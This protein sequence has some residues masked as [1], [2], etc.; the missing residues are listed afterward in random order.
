MFSVPG[1]SAS[2]DNNMINPDLTTWQ[3]VAD[4]AHGVD[5]M[6]VTPYG[7]GTSTF[8]SQ[9]YSLMIQPSSSIEASGVYIWF[10]SLLDGAKLIPG[11]SY[12]VSFYLPCGTD[13][14]KAIGEPE[15][16][17]NQYYNNNT[18]L[19]AS[20]TNLNAS[21]RVGISY[22]SN[23]DIDN[24]DVEL[25]TT[26][27]EISSDNVDSYFGQKLTASFVCPDYIGNAYLT[28]TFG[29][30]TKYTLPFSFYFSD[31]SLIDPND[32]SAELKGI[33]GLLHNFY[34]DFVG[35]V[36]NNEDCPHSNEDNPH[37]SIIQRLFVPSDE[38][39][40][41]WKSDLQ[42]LLQEHLGVIYSASDFIKQLVEQ[43]QS[44]LNNH[45]GDIKMPALSFSLPDG[46]PVHLWNETTVDFA[47]LENG[48]FKTLYG[49]YK[50][51]LNVICIFALIKY[52]IKNWEK[53][54]AN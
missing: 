53:T 49:M 26:L 24:G 44:L 48:I 31:V 28:F 43:M 12:T 14:W 8:P 17:K 50:V 45:Q 20:W 40:E 23:L 19:K 41:S 3:V 1:V 52:A 46:T 35:G 5:I 39:V 7:S 13:I 9:M 38:F 36:C 6:R 22:G 33:K 34:W 4:A 16:Y 42:T 25:K 54:M 11:N 47:F 21:L 37:V 15:A 2:Y 32:S 51:M 29:G 30:N 18:T 10:G 27:F